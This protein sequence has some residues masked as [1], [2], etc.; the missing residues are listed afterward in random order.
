VE[1]LRGV[2]AIVDD[3]CD[4]LVMLRMKDL[5]W[6]CNSRCDPKLNAIFHIKMIVLQFFYYKH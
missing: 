4:F 5:Q 2:V 3:D 6:S 1:Q